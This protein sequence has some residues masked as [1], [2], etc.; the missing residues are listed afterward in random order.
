MLPYLSR[1]ENCPLVGTKTWVALLL[2][3]MF[4]ELDGWW[5]ELL[6]LAVGFLIWVEGKWDG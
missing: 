6:H 4:P 3:G 5:L 1:N 2:F